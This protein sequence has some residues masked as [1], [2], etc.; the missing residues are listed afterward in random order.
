MTKRPPLFDDMAVGETR[1]SAPGTP[2]TFIGLALVACVVRAGGVL[3][4]PFAELDRMAER[5][6]HL[7]RL[8]VL[9][10]SDRQVLRI[11]TTES[12]A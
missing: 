12:D 8:R 4:I 6:S 2:P 1:Q 10:D 7:S 3:E 9:L 11:M 5:P